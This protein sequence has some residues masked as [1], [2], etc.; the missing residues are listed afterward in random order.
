MPSLSIV[1]PTYN[2]VNKLLR[3][4]NNIEAEMVDSNLSH[5]IQIL[6]SDNASSDDTQEVVSNFETTKF[7][8]EYFRQEKNIGF[9]GNV[10]FLYDVAK[11][12]YVWF[13]SDDDILLPGAI[14]MVMNGLLETEP[15]VLLFSFI[16]P[17]GVEI[18]TFNFPDQFAV[19][20]T[21][22]EII[23][24]VA[25]YPK[26]SIYLCRKI[27]LNDAQKSELE[28]F[29]ENGFFWI[30]LCYS[31]IAA[32]KRPQLCVISKPLAR[33]DDDFGNIRFGP[34]LFL[35]SYSIFLHPFVLRN[36]PNMA[37]ERRTKSYY[38]AIQLMFAVKLGSL[39][40][41]DPSLYE[42]EIKS[43]SILPRMLLKN[44]RALMQILALKFKLVSLYK[45]YKRVLALAAKL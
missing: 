40:S 3:L 29:Y 19:I 18:R 1:I 35:K 7:K 31:I 16:Q 20:T 38:D 10:R 6:V 5:L 32:S 43:F 33:C 21:P 36:L 2:R 12:D 8:F 22:K 25:Y 45:I 13:F 15:D 26:V 30:D 11:T 27:E 41:D 28:P 17:L 37:E 9:D 44:P 4:L 34:N 24:F 14:T 39:K 23:K 42:R